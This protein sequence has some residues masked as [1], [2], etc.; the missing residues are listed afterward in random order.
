MFPHAWFNWKLKVFFCG[1]VNLGCWSGFLFAVTR[2]SVIRDCCCAGF[3]IHQ[4]VG[5]VPAMEL[6][7]TS[8][9][10]LCVC[11]ICPTGLKPFCFPSV[12]PD[13]FYPAQELTLSS[14]SWRP[15]L[16]LLN[17]VTLPFFPNSAHHLQ[18]LLGLGSFRD[19]PAFLKVRNFSSCCFPR[20]SC[21]H[22]PTSRETVCRAAQA[23]SDK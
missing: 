19:P 20:C 5:R 13:S 1:A 18:P 15:A 3:Y 14:E 11:A 8:H 4:C 7:T 2:F 23:A 10:L 6:G 22:G 17:Q 21:S 9:S 12:F 16:I